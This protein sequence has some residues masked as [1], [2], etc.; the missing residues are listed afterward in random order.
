[1][2]IDV[3]LGFALGAWVIGLYTPPIIMKV[4]LIGSVVI[5]VLYSMAKFWFR[6]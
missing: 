1:M 3:A 5:E 6:D 4:V 2:I